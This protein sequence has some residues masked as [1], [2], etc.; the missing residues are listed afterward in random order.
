MSNK[1]EKVDISTEETLL[2]RK[3]SYK[4]LLTFTIPTIISF[5]LMAA[6][7]M[8]DGVFASRGISVVALSAVNFVVPFFNF[9]M[10]V[11]AMLSMGGAALVAKKKGKG[12][13]L[14]AR[15]NFTLL[16]V[17]VFII[18]ALTSIISWILRPQLLDLLGVDDFVRSMALDYL[19]P[20]IILM[21]FIMVGMF[22]TQFLI[23]EGKPVLGMFASVS[24]AVVSTSLNALF[25]FVFETGVYGL[26]IA[27]GIGYA[28]PAVLGLIYFSINR[29]GTIYF[30][31]PKWDF[32]ALWRSSANGI[33]EAI[34]MLAMTVTTTVM[35]NVLVDLV[36]FEGV[37]SAGIVMGIQFIFVSLFLGYSAGISPVVSYN[38]GKNK[39]E[40]LEQLY[41]KSL[42][43]ISVL[44][45]IAI[46][47][48][49]VTAS[50]FVTI[51]VPTYAPVH[52]MT[53]RGLRIAATGFIFMGFNVFATNW[54]TAFNDGLVSGVMSFMRTM[55]F[56]TV[57]LVTLPRFWDLNGVWLALS[58]AEVASL[59]LTV[60]FLIKMGEKYK[61]KKSQITV[62]KG[63]KIKIADARS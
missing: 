47:V 37:A 63:Q 38:Y 22:L 42:R 18:S 5:V 4:F 45:M 60:F 27:T 62:V 32:N 36:G 41:K 17:V 57:L 20:L 8:V 56:T 54:F 2:S 24:G 19:Q 14:E 43:I 50:L 16:T 13:G 12:L 46:V 33:S 31:R 51:Y 39:N 30:V 53:V 7:G 10:A 1:I 29:K 25:I 34:T 44:A 23:A 28:F 9:A 21:P 49:V 6:F 52:A 3:I 35:N 40:N 48:A 11:G 59:V 26:A 15:Q 61:Y 58:L 55:V